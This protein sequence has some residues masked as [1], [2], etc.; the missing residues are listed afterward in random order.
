MVLHF[1]LIIIK[2]SPSIVLIY[3][4]NTDGNSLAIKLLSSAV[5]TI[6]CFGAFHLWVLLACGTLMGYDCCRD[7]MTETVNQSH[8]CCISTMRE[9]LKNK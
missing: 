7:S 1:L 8:N 9:W 3:P 4:L 6:L 5:K 2:N